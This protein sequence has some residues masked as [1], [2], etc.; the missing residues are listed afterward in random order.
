MREAH[1]E[2]AAEEQ[3]A[4]EATG[5]ADDARAAQAVEKAQ[6]DRADAGAAAAENERVRAETVV[7]FI[8]RMLSSADPYELKGQNY[9]VRQ[10]LDDFDRDLD[11]RLKGRP[12]AEAALRRTMAKSYLGL[13]L[14]D[15][16]EPH[17]RRAVEISREILGRGGAGRRATTHDLLA[18][19]GTCLLQQQKHAEAEPV[20]RECLAIREKEIPDDWRRYATMSMLG[21]ALCGQG[22]HAEAEP[23][24]VEG[25]E[26]M[27][28]PEDLGVRKREALERLVKLY[29]AWG[30]PEKA[31]EW[32]AKR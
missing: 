2:A 9:T 13:G 14:F 23:L 7:D 28:P 4:A 20:L 29:E 17:A 24:L 21:E 25:H 8:H 31:A 32:R 19:L 5:K 1:L 12:E 18:I 3:A 30:K 16:A 26:R 10:L 11:A 15:Q 22:K 27:M 6:S